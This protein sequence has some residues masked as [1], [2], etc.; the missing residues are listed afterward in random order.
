VVELWETMAEK[1][2][3]GYAKAAAALADTYRKLGL[4]D[5][6]EALLL[7]LAEVETLRSNR[8]R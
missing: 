3:N 5:E 1:D 2:S 6:A 7:D 4:P 8:R